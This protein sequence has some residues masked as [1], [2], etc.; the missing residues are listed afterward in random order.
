MKTM[1]VLIGAVVMLVAT[2]AAAANMIAGPIEPSIISTDNAVCE[3]VNV[4]TLDRTIQMQAI[5]GSGAILN[6]S[7]PFT[8]PA[9]HAAALVS[10]AAGTQYC[11]FIGAAPAYFRASI[12]IY[13]AGT[14]GSDRAALPAQ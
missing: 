1:P 4:T 6:D 11:K 10:G 13:N 12:A 7:G 5:S 8:L 2:E 14:N 3:I 9:G